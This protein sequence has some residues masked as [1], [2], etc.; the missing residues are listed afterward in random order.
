MNDT[1]PTRNIKGE[2][3]STSP[4]IIYDSEMGSCLSFDGTDDYAYFET[5]SIANDWFGWGDWWI[6]AWIKRT[7]GSGGRIIIGNY[8]TGSQSYFWGLYGGGT[9]GICL[10]ERENNINAIKV[11]TKLYFFGNHE[12]ARKV[13]QQA[14][15]QFPFS[16]ILENIDSKIEMEKPGPNKAMEKCCEIIAKWPYDWEAYNNLG[17]LLYRQGEFENAYKFLST[18]SEIN[19]EHGPLRQSLEACKSQLG[20]Q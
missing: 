18:A 5:N 16:V 4:S 8:E 12:E 19:P 1:M 15:D 9:D 13:L 7:S 20:I 11:I 3:A 14:H 10:Y 2:V 17:I 6:S